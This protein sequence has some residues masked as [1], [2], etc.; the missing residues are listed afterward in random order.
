MFPPFQAQISD[1]LSPDDGLLPEL[2][3]LAIQNRP[4]I[5]TLA[6]DNAPERVSSFDVWIARC[7]HHDFY[8]TAYDQLLARHIE[9][10]RYLNTQE[11][12]KLYDAIITKQDELKD[13]YI[14]LSDVQNVVQYARMLLRSLDPEVSC[15]RRLFKR[16]LKRSRNRY[17]ELKY[18]AGCYNK[19]VGRL[20]AVLSEETKRTCDFRDAEAGRS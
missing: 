10:Y 20:W 3:A 2:Q 15:H 12:D 19:R 18:I 6:Q 7:L 17:K 14:S 16:Q 5:L 13:V 9:E 1:D 8:C 11:L 4:S